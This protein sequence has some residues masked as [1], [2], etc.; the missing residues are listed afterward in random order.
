MDTEQIIQTVTTIGIPV[1]LKI[2][3]VLGDGP[4]TDK[5]D[6]VSPTRARTSKESLPSWSFARAT[7]SQSHP[8]TMLANG[9]PL[10]IGFSA[11]SI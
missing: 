3:A 4:I 2:I 5:T 1:G 6:G 7:P 11:G 9:V 8:E 10:D